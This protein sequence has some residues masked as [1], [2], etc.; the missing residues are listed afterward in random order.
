MSGDAARGSPHQQG[1]TRMTARRAILTATLSLLVSPAHAEDEAEPGRQPPR[2][3]TPRPMTL[4][5]G[6]APVMLEA[7]IGEGSRPPLL[8]RF[9]GPDAPRA[10]F[11]FPSW[12][13]YARLIAV[14]PMRGRDIAFVAFEGNTGTGTYQ[15]IQAAIG[16]DDD[17]VLRILALETLHYR[18]NGPCDSG[19]WLTI[20]A[21]PLADGGGLRLNQFW[22]RQGAACPPRPG[23]P[24][25]GR[26]EWGTTL[27]WSGRGPMRGPPPLPGA[28]PARRL[29]ETARATVMAWLAAA[30][31][32]AVTADDIE[33]LGLMQTLEDG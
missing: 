15:E 28:P 17:G 12:Y 2:L 5:P 31:R 30:P 32:M 20:R 9:S 18:L 14:R 13:G 23:G 22:R 3:P 25:R 26:L 11:R 33:A 19:A 4:R 1:E 8:V 24:A 6:T 7:G 29:V 21:T 16:Q 27:L 10:E